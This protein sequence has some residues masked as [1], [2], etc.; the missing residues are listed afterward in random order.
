M[1]SRGKTRFL[2]LIINRYASPAGEVSLQATEGLRILRRTALR[3][4]QDDRCGGQCNHITI[5]PSRLVATHRL[6]AV[7]SQLC[8][9]TGLAFTTATALRLP[10]TQGR[11]GCG[12][13]LWMGAGHRPRFRTGLSRQRTVPCLPMLICPLKQ[14]PKNS[15]TYP[16]YSKQSKKRNQNAGY[17]KDLFLFFQLCKLIYQE[18][19]GKE[20][21]HH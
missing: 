5:P 10:F 3:L 8:Q 15:N 9:P 4:A 11:L 13:R 6:R 1:L 7:R 2:D 18:Q 14:R 20:V 17:A 21:E 19:Q 12:G 16:Y